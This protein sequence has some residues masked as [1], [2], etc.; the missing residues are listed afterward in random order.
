[1][2]NK[3]R[4]LKLVSSRD[5]NVQPE[6]RVALIASI[7]EIE[8]IVPWYLLPF[9]AFIPNPYHLTLQEFSEELVNSQEIPTWTK[10]C[11][12]FEELR[13]YLKDEQRRVAHK[14]KLSVVDYTH[15]LDI[16]VLEFN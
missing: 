10:Q 9:S 14:G 4:H 15:K 3:Q 6:T 12:S 2:G 16:I 13:T 11:N 5:D 8:V 1:M 7:T